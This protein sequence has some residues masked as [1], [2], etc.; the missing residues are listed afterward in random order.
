M[1]MKQTNALLLLLILVVLFNNST[2][3]EIPSSDIT[4]D[5]TH[6]FSLKVVGDIMF[7]FKI[8]PIDL[9]LIKAKLCFFFSMYCGLTELSCCRSSDEYAIYIFQIYGFDY[10]LKK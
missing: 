2:N 9:Y 6:Y 4:C 5:T 7:G 1:K 3:S 8:L 10:N